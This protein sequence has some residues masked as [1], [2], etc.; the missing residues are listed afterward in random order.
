MGSAARDSTRGDGGYHHS[1]EF[2]LPADMMR[3]L[4]RV[5]TYSDQCIQCFCQAHPRLDSSSA[6]CLDSRFVVSVTLPAVW[7]VFAACCSRV[8]LAFLVCG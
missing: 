5:M 8:R 6:S 7:P 4:P 3:E 2:W 1:A